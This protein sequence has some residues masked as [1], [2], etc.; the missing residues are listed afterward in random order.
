MQ[1]KLSFIVIIFLFSWMDIYVTAALG[2]NL[3]IIITIITEWG[4]FQTSCI[5]CSCSPGLLLQQTHS[6]MAAT[7]AMSKKLSSASLDTCNSEIDRQWVCVDDW[8]PASNTEDVLPLGLRLVVDW[9]ASAENHSQHHHPRHQADVSPPHS[10]SCLLNL[11]EGAHEFY[12][13]VS[14]DKSS[15][16]ISLLCN[17]LVFL[18]DGLEMIRGVVWQA[19]YIYR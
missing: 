6:I 11:Q 9:S 19:S 15:W 1:I 13:R 7:L 14:A 4:L 10:S 18:W 17:Q 16:S 5:A 8:T 2:L 12:V 3:V